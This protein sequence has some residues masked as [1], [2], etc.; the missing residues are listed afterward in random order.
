MFQQLLKNGWVDAWRSRNKD[1]Q[2]FTWVSTKQKN[3][4]RY[5]HAL[6]STSIN[7]AITEVRYNHNVRLEGISD[8]SMLILNANV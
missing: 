4:F 5:D 2:E 7:K 6:V 8:H 3:G 1:K